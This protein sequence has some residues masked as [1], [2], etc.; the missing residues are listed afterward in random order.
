MDHNFVLLSF[1]QLWEKES[2]IQMLARFS[3]L[4]THSLNPLSPDAILTWSH[5]PS[6]I[7]FGHGFLL[8]TLDFHAS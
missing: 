6:A 1:S 2:T 8:H 5:E 4:G 7:Y 3:S